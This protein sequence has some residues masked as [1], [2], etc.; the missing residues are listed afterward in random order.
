MSTKTYGHLH[1]DDRAWFIADSFKWLVEHDR[2][3]PMRAQKAHVCYAC[4]GAIPAGEQYRRLRG[5]VARRYWSA[6]LALVPPEYLR[7]QPDAPELMRRFAQHYGVVIMPARVR[8]ARDKA[9]VENA[10]R[11]TY[12]RIYAPLRDRAFHS[13]D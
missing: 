7:R 11:L 8:Q 6:S 4:G 12:Q 10:V 3:E 9:L 13:L 1:E 2:G 5:G